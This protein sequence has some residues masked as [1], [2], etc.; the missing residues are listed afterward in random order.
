MDNLPDYKPGN[1]LTCGEGDNYS[2]I[3]ILTEGKVIILCGLGKG[4]I[5]HIRDWYILVGKNTVTIQNT[6]LLDNCQSCPFY[7][8]KVDNSVGSSN[9]DIEDISGH[10]KYRRKSILAGPDGLSVYDTPITVPEPIVKKT[11]WFE[12]ILMCGFSIDD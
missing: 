10:N 1:I 4:N 2:K 7:T 9:G 12:R 8:E 5:L 6:T 3:K 11:T